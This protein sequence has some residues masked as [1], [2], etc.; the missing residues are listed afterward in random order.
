MRKQDIEL[1]KLSDPNRVFPR[2]FK[3]PQNN[4]PRARRKMI[5]NA[6]KQMRRAVFR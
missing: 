6:R 3:I 1:P 4:V 5:N 2:S